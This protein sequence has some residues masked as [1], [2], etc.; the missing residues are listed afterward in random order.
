[1]QLMADALRELGGGAGAVPDARELEPLGFL[2]YQAMT[3][4]SRDYH[5]LAHAFVVAEGLPP[6]GRLAAIYH[7]AVYFHVD[8]GFS[9][10]VGARI[11]DV[12][13]QRDGKLFLPPRLDVVIAD[14][15]V[16][17]GFTAGQELA[18]YGGLSEFLSAALATRELQRF[19]PRKALWAIAA[20]IE[21]TIPFRKQ[22]AGGTPTE[23]LRARLGRLGEGAGALTEGESDEIL[24]LATRLANSDVQSFGQQDLSDFLDDTWKLLPETNPEFRQVGAYSIRRYREALSRTEAFLSS[25]DPGVIFRQHRAT[26]SDA[27][28]QALRTRAAINL[29]AASEYLR[30]K[31]AAM[32][33]LEALAELSGG[34]GP[35]SYFTGAA[36]SGESQAHELLQG[37]GA[38]G[39]SPALDSSV[40][41][42]L[43]GGRGS[44]S[45]FD[46]SASP[47]AAFL[48]ER[49]G[50]EGTAE[51]VRRARD[52]HAG[53]RDWAWFL[54]GLPAELVIDVAQ[55]VA[56]IATARRERI[57]QIIRDCSST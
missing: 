16:V 10:E 2:A 55:A 52:V 24:V 33:V 29:R 8:Q 20:C 15:A 40:L 18:V 25:L 53:K 27:D 28:Y 54:R 7:D 34:D 13:E 44:A 37:A 36:G 35:I 19:L 21:A 49:L 22:V 39:A 48:Y 31:I 38:P 50:S 3:G 14:L 51:H 32:L 23:A 5:G 56:A 43:R 4:R 26:P 42:V 11:G 1:M 6:L 9:P 46:T 12:V 45:R 47:L 30:A 17:F 41:R 57:L